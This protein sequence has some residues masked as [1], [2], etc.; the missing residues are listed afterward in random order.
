M[1]TEIFSL[2]QPLET[3]CAIVVHHFIELETLSD[4]M[5]GFSNFCL[6]LILNVQQN[7]EKRNIREEILENHCEG[8]T[9]KEIFNIFTRN[10]FCIFERSV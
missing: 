6:T 1:T 2:Q 3:H 10:I 4:K 8:E 9:S 5:F 7:S